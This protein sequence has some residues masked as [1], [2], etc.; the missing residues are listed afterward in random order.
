[1]RVTRERFAGINLDLVDTKACLRNLGAQVSPQPAELLRVCA[2][3]VGERR[4]VGQPTERCS[5]N[6]SQRP[7]S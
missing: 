1:V 7:L 4:A 5:Q 2:K 3:F 6:S